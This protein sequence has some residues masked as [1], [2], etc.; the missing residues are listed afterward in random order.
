MAYAWTVGVGADD[1]SRS[2]LS[3]RGNFAARANSAP[4]K[5][6]IP[7]SNR[8]AQIL[9]PFPKIASSNS[10]PKKIHHDAKP[11]PAILNGMQRRPS[12]TRPRQNFPWVVT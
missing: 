12:H 4:R 7:G 10:R 11:G 8:T 5:L 1:F 9:R 2:L 3:T 6:P